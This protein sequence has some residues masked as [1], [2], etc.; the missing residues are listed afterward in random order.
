[1]TVTLTVGV[2]TLTRQLPNP[3]FESGPPSAAAQ[4]ER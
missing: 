4:R 2:Q 3:A 1:M